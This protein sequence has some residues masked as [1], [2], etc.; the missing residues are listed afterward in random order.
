LTKGPLYE[1][2]FGDVQSANTIRIAKQNKLAKSSGPGHGGEKAT[3]EEEDLQSA[4]SSS[5]EKV[6]HTMDA[7]LDTTRL[8]SFNTRVTAWFY[9]RSSGILANLTFGTSARDE[10]QKEA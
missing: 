2:N 5:V 6:N 4:K 7:I 1:A 9:Q 3:I 8:V 10:G